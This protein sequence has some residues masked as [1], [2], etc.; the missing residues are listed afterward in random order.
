MT[1]NSI[2]R[3]NN[4]QPEV[5]HKNKKLDYNKLT[6]SKHFWDVTLKKQFLE[7]QNMCKMYANTMINGKKLSVAKGSH[8]ERSTISVLE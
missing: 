3:E 8:F 6:I 5:T 4:N 2:N 7:L 1:N